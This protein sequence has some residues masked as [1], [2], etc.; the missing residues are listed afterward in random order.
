MLEMNSLSKYKIYSYNLLKISLKR[1]GISV[2]NI[3]TYYFL[4]VLFLQKPKS[5]KTPKIKADSGSRICIVDAERYLMRQ[6]N[7]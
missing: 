5:C 1:D 7:F 6:D 3:P 2:L 4:N